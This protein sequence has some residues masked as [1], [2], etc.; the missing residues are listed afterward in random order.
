MNL[1][2]GSGDRRDT[3]PPRRR[4]NFW[5]RLVLIL[6]GGTASL[7]VLILILIQYF[8]A[9]RFLGPQVENVLENLLQREVELGD[10]ESFSLTG[11]RL[12]RTVIPATKKQPDT[13]TVQS[14]RVRYNPLII[15]AQR[16]LN[17]DIA[18]IEAD[19][20]LEQRDKRNWFDIPPFP[21]SNFPI[22]VNVAT[23]R[24]F[25][26]NLTAVSRYPD[27]KFQ[28]PIRVTATRAIVRLKKNYEDIQ[29]TALEGFFPEGGKFSIQGEGIVPDKKIP[30]LKAKL[31][32][33]ASKINLAE[34]KNI[35]PIRLEKYRIADLQ[36]EAD[37]KATI[38]IA[39]NPF[40][41]KSL[42]SIDGSLTIATIAVASDLISQPLTIPQGK[43]RLQG[44]TAKLEN[45]TAYLGEIA[46]I[47]QG[48]V[49]EEL[50]FDVTAMVKPVA[51]S[52]LFKTVEIKPPN[53]PF[54][55]AIS[56]ESELTGYFDRMQLSGTVKNACLP[57]QSCSFP[58]LDRIAL[59]TI[60]VDFD[61]SVNQKILTVDRFIVNPVL[62]GEI[63]GDAYLSLQ[64]KEAIANIKAE[65]LSVTNFANLYD[66]KLQGLPFNLGT[67]SARS[68]V[69]MPL[70]NWQ[71]F[72]AT[73][74]SNV[75]LG[76]GQIT[77]NNI[78]VKEG[79]Y[80]GTI[81]VSDVGL[82]R[83]LPLPDEVKQQIGTANAKL[84]LSG[85]LGNF[86]LAAIV[87]NAIVRGDA[88]LNL[89][90][91]RMQINDL[92][93]T[94][95]QFS[96]IA[97]SSGVNVGKII[98]ISLR[99]RFPLPPLET[100]AG[101]FKINGT[102]AGFFPEK[103]VGTGKMSLGIAGGEG[104]A[105]GFEFV[106]NTLSAR[107]AADG[108]QVA[109][110]SRLITLPADLKINR[111][112]LGIVSGDA[113]IAYQL[114]PDKKLAFDLDRVSLQG[115]GKVENLARGIAQ[116]NFKVREGN[117]QA[118]IAAAGIAPSQ[119]TPQIPPNLDAIAAGNL[120]VTG[121]LNALNLQGIRATGTG[122][123][124]AVGGKIT[125]NN[126]LLE[127]GKLQANLVPRGLQVSRVSPELRGAL[128]GDINV[129]ANL[130]DFKPTSLNAKGTIHLNEGISLIDRPL[131]AIFAWNGSR[132]NIERARAA[133]QL[134][135]KGYLD[136]N[137]IS[138]LERDILRALGKFNFDANIQNI[139]LA[140]VKTE[141]A[142]FT[143]LGLD[144]ESVSLSG[145]VGF[146]GEVSGSLRSPS[147]AGQVSL[148]NVAF[149][150]L[151]LDP[152]LSGEVN[153]VAGEGG[154]ADIR[155]ESD[156][157][158]ATIDRDYLPETFTINLDEFTATGEREGNILNAAIANFPL[159]F[160]KATAPVHL[161]P[162]I[163]AAQPVAG[164]LEGNFSID[165]QAWE[166]EGSVAI[167]DPVFGPV[168]GDRFSGKVAYANGAIFLQEGD[169][170][171]GET[172][173]LLDARVSEMFE[174]PQ[175]QGDVKITNGDIQDLLKTFRLKDFQDFLR[176]ARTFERD[177]PG[178]AEDLNTL[179]VG[180]TSK[181]S[182]LDRL[183]RLS[184]I[185][186]LLDLQEEE[187]RRAFP[188]PPLA[189]LRGNFDGTIQLSA[190]LREGF[191]GTNAEFDLSG[192][193]W[194]WGSF[195]VDTIVAK[196]SLEKGLI[197]LLPLEVKAGDGF[198]QASGTYGGQG[199]SGKVDV[200]EFPILLLQDLLPL[201]P[202]IG[203]G[204]R[205]N[206]TAN[207]SG[208][209]ENPQA[210]GRVD[211]ADAQI[212]DTDVYSAEG[213]FSYNKARLRF[214]GRSLLA[215]EGTPL[216]LTGVIP[217]RL[218]IP[219]AL[220]PEDTTLSLKAK[221]KD[222]GL[223]I[224]NILTRQQLEWEEGKGEVDVDV[225]G[226]IDPDSKQLTKLVADG[227]IRL[228]NGTVNLQIVPDPIT[229]LNGEID[230]NIDR[231]DVKQ[232]TGKFGGGDIV[233]AGT[234]PTFLA[235]PQENPLTV[236]LD[237]LA[238][239]LKG[240]LQ[241]D[242]LGKV[243]IAGSAI[244]PRI[245]GALEVANGSLQ[246]LG[247]AGASGG[248]L[249][250]GNSAIAEAV[251]FDNL[252]LTLTDNFAIEQLPVLQFIAGGRFWVNGTLADLQPQGTI[253]L[254]RGFVNLF[255]STLRLDG[256]YDNIA[257]FVPERGLDPELD[258][259]LVGSVLET[260]RPIVRNDT[261]TSEIR[262]TPTNIGSVQT[263][264]VE[265]KVTST[266]FELADS[267]KTSAA[268]GGQPAQQILTL[269]STPQ[270]GET[271]IIALLGGGFINAVAGGDNT[272]LA[273]GLANI[274]GTALLGGVENQIADAFGLDSF[275][276]FPAEVID[277]TGRTETLGVAI[278]LGKD[279][280]RRFSISVLQY[281][282]PPDQPT[283]FNTQY[284]LNDNFTVRGSTDFSGDS[285]LSVEFETRF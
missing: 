255:T 122:A 156:R 81:L 224:I 245:S 162:R 30:N 9:P 161:F 225:E 99:D 221:L 117:W 250:G 87:D 223:A 236:D 10:V 23:V 134:D 116:A 178:D 2:P 240:L 52:T 49:S 177:A 82:G 261:V 84:N 183:R 77:V 15:L 169:L 234:L 101:E 277:D 265:A 45:I 131:D 170:S 158:L 78:Q 17:L 26:G 230:L 168:S 195:A 239:N 97:R 226:F 60:D 235:T 165:L 282:T 64:G 72:N 144:S 272:A 54:S 94:K 129:N 89:A 219:I 254:N 90:G 148:D 258:L 133:D 232:L 110:L 145:F 186:T 12:G 16:K 153:F 120:N 284:R 124:A 20:Y 215:E 91:G 69:S 126:I 175:I 194:D 19:A 213:T 86:D 56:V 172:Q 246:V 217:Y 74:S 127:A 160:A 35:V 79:R 180:S 201:P 237:T 50:G 106:N 191:A 141:I 266:A 184:E 95:G 8:I 149:N 142:R 36:G 34:L 73:V 112:S 257:R 118:A 181:I 199:I 55:G 167:A 157:I 39:G 256:S 63:T 241:G 22:T 188:V 193:D 176:L 100:L 271:E 251:S 4:R 14:I 275:S 103:I 21:K 68:R 252:Q 107:V 270:R 5:L 105:T 38:D 159:A 7:L 205:I 11:L 268:T 61:I 130:A 96:T 229:H 57:K 174:N 166:A 190:K 125:A 128:N 218:P 210:R 48:T 163:I 189:D 25:D 209:Q 200:T 207:L 37:I 71:N 41:L 53:I 43:I 249:A 147:L 276:V 31:N 151:V 203:F 150:H 13:A 155:G 115:T 27:G 228:E 66:I 67:L 214:S 273:G 202:A 62:G 248:G 253:N 119:I 206:L 192:V 238:L 247:A 285:R 231:I 152:V 114:L 179:T 65:N 280:G 47:V 222:D 171:E 113:A 279:F 278:E 85:S 28:P 212:N 204:G 267:L 135:A 3:P 140:R 182:I 208:T 164:N 58:Q 143:A 18:L 83:V 80:G 46:T 98:P 93:F 44:K 138:L 262:D 185:Q 6:G 260:S 29:I 33:T 259:L 51:F 70:D 59:K 88:I 109:E 104:S 75:L 196:G 283:R 139:D 121:S 281:L 233:A 211:I 108:I 24:V 32:V 198:V 111:K 123:I 244:E 154:S 146:A 40:S 274:A 220:P 269:D 227:K 173:Y 102:I 242:I 92:N 197:T 187:R 264:R 132:L 1:L 136:V 216:T 137:L 76:D 263:L 243:Q 42:P